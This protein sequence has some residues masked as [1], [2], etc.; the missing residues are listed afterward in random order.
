MTLAA[1]DR[2]QEE[3][4][5]PAAALGFKTQGEAQTSQEREEHATPNGERGQRHS[6]GGGILNCAL[7][8]M[9]GGG[10]QED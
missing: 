8:K 7:R 9:T 10:H 5:E 6:L 3:Q 4:Q 2:R 1:P